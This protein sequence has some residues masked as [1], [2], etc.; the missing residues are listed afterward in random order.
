MSVVDPSEINDFDVTKCIGFEFVCKDKHEV[1]TK[2][3]VIKVDEDTGKVLLEYVYGGLELIEPIILQETLLSRNQQEDEDYIWPLSKILNHRTV[4]NGKIKVEVLQD[5]GETSWEPL[6]VLHKDDP[7]TLAGYIK[8]RRLLEQHNWKWAKSI[9]R[10][11][12]KFVR[13]LKLMKVSKKYQK[14]L[15]G[16]K[17]YKF[18]MQ[19]PR[20]GDV[21][22]AMK[23][24]QENGN[25][26]WFDAQ[27]KEASMLRDLATFELM[28][29][30][31]DLTGY[32]YVPPIYAW[33]VKFDGRRR[34]RLVANGKVTIGP[35]EEDVWSEVVNTK[36]VCTAI[37]LAMLNRMKILAADISSAY[38]MA[39]MKEIIY[40][41]LDP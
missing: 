5:N 29:E 38:L 10:H 32:Q 31:F 12:K 35:P 19:V 21:R 25:S 4:T 36:S 16:K 8:E 30:N 1:P 27:K 17:T 18:G 3:K 11:K 7:V 28:P 9:A 20:T 22:G 39:D 23:L 33:D 41:R 15:Y 13:M 40:T 2:T 6:A 37:F 34:A 26:L 24:D 14:K